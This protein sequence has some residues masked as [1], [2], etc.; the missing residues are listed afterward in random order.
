MAVTNIRTGLEGYAQLEI[1][2][3]AF[4]KNGLVVSQLPLSDEF[5]AA[6]PCENGMWVDADK[7]NGEIKLPSANTKVFGIVY[8]TEKEYNDGFYGL[9]QFHQVEGDYPRVGILHQGDTFTTSCV[10]LDTA[11]YDT[12][13]K[14]KTAIAS[15]L[16]VNY[17]TDGRPQLATTGSGT[18]YGKVIAL[19]T[20]PNGEKAIKYNI[21]VA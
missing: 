16:Y 12:D 5:T 13:A 11:T 8:T 6:V 4:L 18:C 3:A 17:S 9:K 19:T 2:R 14:I 1:N 20:M 10:K 7:A 15:G 21:V